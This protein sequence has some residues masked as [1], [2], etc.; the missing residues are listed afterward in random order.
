MHEKFAWLV[1]LVRHLFHE[2]TCVLGIG[3]FISNL[4]NSNALLIVGVF[5]VLNNCT[6]EG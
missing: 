5:I 4:P 1:I 2:S 6:E 3:I